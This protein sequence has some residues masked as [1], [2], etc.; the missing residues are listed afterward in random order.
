MW[1]KNVQVSA[2]HLLPL[3]REVRANGCRVLLLE[4]VYFSYKNFADDRIVLRPSGDF[5]LAM[6]VT[7]IL[8]RKVE[9]TR[10]HSLDATMSRRFSRSSRTK[11]LE[12]WCADADVS[13]EDARTIA[14]M[15]AEGPTTILVGWGMQRRQNGAAIVRALDALAAITGNLGKPGAGVSFYFKRRGSFDTSWKSPK[16]HAARTIPEPLLGKGI[17][18]MTAPRISAAFITC[19]N[20]VAMLPGSEEIARAL[21]QLDWLVVTDTHMTDT[22][23]LATWVLPTTTLLEADDLPG[24]RSSYLGSGRARCPKARW[25]LE[26]PGDRPRTGPAAWLWSGIRRHRERLEEPKPPAGA[27]AK[28]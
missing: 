11:S 3:L 6:A 24:L 8:V 13:T 27:R 25:S 28:P 15:L 21:A 9:S 17:L 10:T 22:A 23:R 7:R 20:P 12:L 16:E 5:A 2:P 19:C 1:G 18:A 4:P 26:R 14:R